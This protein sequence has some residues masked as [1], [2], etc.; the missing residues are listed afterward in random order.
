MMAGAGLGVSMSLH[1][2]RFGYQRDQAPAFGDRSGGLGEV[3]RVWVAEV[4]RL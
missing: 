1:H 2:P 4:R 3:S